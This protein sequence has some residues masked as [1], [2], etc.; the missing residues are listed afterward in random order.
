MSW[1]LMIRMDRSLRFL[2]LKDRTR[3]QQGKE[4]HR[5]TQRGA[6]RERYR[7]PQSAHSSGAGHLKGLVTS[8]CD[9]TSLY[10]TEFN[11]SLLIISCVTALTI[12]IHYPR[13]PVSL[14]F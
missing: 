7:L 4:T 3:W 1:T 5:D 2:L 14:R 13:C 11:V 12:A 9:S 10:S 6:A 8:A